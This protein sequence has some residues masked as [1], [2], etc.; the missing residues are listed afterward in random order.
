MNPAS[1]TSIPR[2]SPLPSCEAIRSRYSPPWSETYATCFPSGLHAGDR[3]CAPGVLVHDAGF[4]FGLEW[5]PDGKRIAYYDNS[6][7]IWVLDVATGACRR[8]ASNRIY[9]PLIGIT[10][11]WS[12]DSRW[13]AYT[14]ETHP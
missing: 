9:T 12:P 8:V 10:S 2:G 5:S 6:Q 7:T 3:S 4:I 13:L 11:A 14:V 1:C